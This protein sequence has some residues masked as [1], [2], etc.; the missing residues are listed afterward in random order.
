MFGEKIAIVNICK[1]RTRNL[2]PALLTWIELKEVNSINIFDFGS[3]LPVHSFL[4]SYGLLSDK[5]IHIFRSESK[6]EFHRTKYWNIALFHTKESKLLKLDTDY[7]IHPQF[8]EWHPL[9]ADRL[10]YTGNWKTA[11]SKNESYLHGLVYMKKDDFVAVNGYNER[12]TGYGWED[13]EIYQRMQDSGCLR[14]DVSYDHAYH[15]PHSHLERIKA[16]SRKNEGVYS[17]RQEKEWKHESVDQDVGTGWDAIYHKK[18]EAELMRLVFENK[19]KAESQP[20]GVHDATTKVKK[21][22]TKGQ[23]TIFEY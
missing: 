1:N 4:D 23:L 15:V 16:D 14:V 18:I 5:R 13:D 11:R 7:K 20:W 2:I 8:L 6:E 22:K 3:D 19:E 10:F 21:A 17:G 12:L 9:S